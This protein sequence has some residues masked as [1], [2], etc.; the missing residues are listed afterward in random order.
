L[1]EA[2]FADAIDKGIS[3]FWDE[4]KALGPIINQPHGNARI[5][6]FVSF[7]AAANF[8]AAL[9]KAD[10]RL[11][12]PLTIAG[13]YGLIHL[14]GGEASGPAL[15]TLIAIARA[16][17]AGTITISD[18]FAAA[19]SLGR[20]DVRTQPIGECETPGGDIMTLYGLSL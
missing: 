4:A 16:T 12:Y 2:A 20:S 19:L 6:G 7:T 18:E 5:F 9:V 8:A 10:P 15:G 13:H 3:A 11:G 1:Q 14:I 17:M